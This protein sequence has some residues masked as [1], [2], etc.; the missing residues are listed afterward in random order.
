MEENRKKFYDVALSFAGKDA[1]PRD[2]V[3]DEVACASTLNAIHKQA[4]GSPIGGGA[5]TYRLYHVL[6]DSPD[7]TKIDQPEWG[8][9]IISPSGYGSGRLAH[10]HAGILDD[11]DNIMSNDSK[12]GLFIKNY[13]LDTWAARYK[14]L[15]GYPVAY[16]RRI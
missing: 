1:T 7:F 16:F 2:E 13:T 4:F 11:K 9:I 5:S 8:A 3:P 10:G 15:G 6:L 14:V 12:S